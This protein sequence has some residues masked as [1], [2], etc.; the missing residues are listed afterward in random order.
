MM[1]APYL[2][3][4]AE[5]LLRIFA[6]TLTSIVA[7]LSTTSIFRQNNYARVGSGAVESAVKQIDRRMNFFGAQWKVENVPQML[8]LRTCYLNGLLAI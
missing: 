7:G 4:A 8:K 6:L 2:L 3:I 1:Q 5:N